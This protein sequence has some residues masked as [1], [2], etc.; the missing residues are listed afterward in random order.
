M[1]QRC[2]CCKISSSSLFSAL[3]LLLLLL[4]LMCCCCSSNAPAAAT[5]AT[6]GVCSNIYCSIAENVHQLLLI[7]SY[8]PLL[9]FSCCN[10][11]A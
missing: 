2:I 4:L 6:A 1:H 8:Q 5:A 7:T 9:Q 3:L 10:A 11:A